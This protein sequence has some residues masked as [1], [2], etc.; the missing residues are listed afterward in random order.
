VVGCLPSDSLE[1]LTVR[2]VVEVNAGSP[3]LAEPKWPRDD[4]RPRHTLF[5]P[6][7]KVGRSLPD[8]DRTGPEKAPGA[9][10]GS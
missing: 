4:V 8:P 5:L 10:K 2:G 1:M 9:L 6:F 3:G 7:K